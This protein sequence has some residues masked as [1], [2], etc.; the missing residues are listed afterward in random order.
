MLL[1]RAMRGERLHLGEG[2]ELEFAELESA[3]EALANK[4]LPDDVELEVL[5]ALIDNHLPPGREGRLE[6]WHDNERQRDLLC[7]KRLLDVGK[8]AY[9]AKRLRDQGVALRL[10]TQAVRLLKEYR[11]QSSIDHRDLHGFNKVPNAELVA[12]MDE[13]MP[14]AEA[15]MEAYARKLRRESRRTADRGAR[16]VP[17][18]R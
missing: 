17:L 7:A 14:G 3:R 13:H 1:Q 9:G 2:V 6:S 4:R 12:D 18:G 8:Q 15:K 11:P 10:R 16:A 5:L